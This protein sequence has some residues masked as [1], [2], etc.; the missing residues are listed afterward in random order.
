[1][2]DP[3][4]V[5]AKKEY[6][7]DLVHCSL[8]DGEYEILF[9]IAADADP[10]PVDSGYTIEDFK[11]QFIKRKT[12]TNEHGKETLTITM[13]YNED[14]YAKVSQWKENTTPLTYTVDGLTKDPLVFADVYARVP[15]TPTITP[16]KTGNL[17]YDIELNFAGD[18]RTAA[19][20]AAGE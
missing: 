19:E 5:S 20:P 6:S 7:S 3:T 13:V 8:S 16:G 1:M 14:E 9:D 4:T 11:S 17:T 12:V 18:Y 2:A 15:K 10:I